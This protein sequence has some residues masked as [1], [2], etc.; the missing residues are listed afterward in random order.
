M[1]ILVIAG[2]ALA[3]AFAGNNSGL[4]GHFGSLWV[5]HDTGNVKLSVTCVGGIG[6]T[7]P[8]DPGN[9][10]HFPKTGPNLLFHGSLLLANAEDY[11]VDRFFGEGA[12]PGHDTDFVPIDSLERGTIHGYQEYACLMH[13]GNHPN[14]KGLQVSQYTIATADS[15][16]EDFVIFLCEIANPTDDSVQ[17]LYFGA[18]CD[19]DIATANMNRAGS[20]TIKRCVWMIPQSNEYPTVGAKLLAPEGWANLCCVDHERWVYPDTEV[21]ERTKYRLLSGDIRQFSSNRDYD[22]SL[23]ASWGPFDLAPGGTQQVDFAML[24][25][26]NT[27]DF[28]A[29]CDSAQSFYIKLLGISEEQ[30][31]P[32]SS[33]LRV[34]PNPFNSCANIRLS[35]EVTGNVSVRV[36]DVAGKVVNTI[37]DGPMPRTGLVWNGYDQRGNLARNGIYFIEV[38]GANTN[39]TCKLVLTR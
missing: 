35:P 12:Q 39:Q 32:V 19:F 4:P 38:D 17:G 21:S 33:A 2:L 23:M 20:D 1:R 27:D 29:N 30:Q 5:N 8:G 26:L 25:G 9:G 18:W 16:Y 34:F 37:W 22:W 10:M 15:G 3:T 13:D 6:S 24:G 31:T 36:Y 28:L 14:A 11:V 7:Q